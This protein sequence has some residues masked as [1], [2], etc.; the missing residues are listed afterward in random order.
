MTSF[1]TQVAGLQ[2]LGP[3]VEGLHVTVGTPVEEALKA[4]GRSVPEPIK[5][6][7][8]ID[9]GASATV[10]RQGMASQPGLKPVGA[11]RV[12]PVSSSN[13]RCYQY[14]VRLL[15][16]NN[17]IVEI[18]VIEAPLRGQ[19]IQGLIGRDVLAHGVLIYIG[20]SNLFSLSF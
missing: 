2:E 9:T 13:V 3:I 12:N 20:Y 14:A 11:I 5:L 19:G 1:T 18:P 6:T 10:V 4:A 7:A 15:F 17:V 16:P 8:L